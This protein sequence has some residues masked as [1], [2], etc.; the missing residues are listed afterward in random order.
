MQLRIKDYSYVRLN[1]ILKQ[2]I[3]VLCISVHYA[4]TTKLPFQGL[5]SIAHIHTTIMLYILSI[6]MNL[7]IISSAI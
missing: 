6:H 1:S 5:V 3:V 2:A 4:I 7:H